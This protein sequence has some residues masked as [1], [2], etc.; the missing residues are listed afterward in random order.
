MEIQINLIKQL[1]MQLAHIFVRYGDQ[2]D[3][4]MYKIESLVVEWFVKG[5]QNDKG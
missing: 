5:L 4:L 3:E 2:T 1:R